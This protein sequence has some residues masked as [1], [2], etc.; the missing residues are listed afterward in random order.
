MR[1]GERVVGCLMLAFMIALVTCSGPTP[2][3]LKS[4]ISKEAISKICDSFQMAQ[5]KGYALRAYTLYAELCVIKRD[6]G[7]TS[8]EIS[9]IELGNLYRKAQCDFADDETFCKTEEWLHEQIK[10][11]CLCAEMILYDQQ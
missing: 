4:S 7:L 11:E 3:K 5:E 9:D 10:D 8:C 2:R 1:K 6:A